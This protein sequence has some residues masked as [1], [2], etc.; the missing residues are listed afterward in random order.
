MGVV[1][2]FPEANPSPRHGR[3]A[4]RLAIVAAPAT[5]LP[6]VTGGRR[7]EY[8]LGDVA[9]QLRMSHL[10]TRTIIAKLRA[11]AQHEQMPLPRTP[12]VIDGK[13][14]RGPDCIY[15]LSRW[16]AGEFDAWLE[17]SSPTSPAGAP[18][19]LAAPIREDMRRR[20]AQIAGVA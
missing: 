7:G 5:D 18:A 20:A 17:G 9:R 13:P 16:D 6:P 19:V 3:G 4:P 8:A 15:R 14:V 1:Q 10:G 12:R 2:L 11:L